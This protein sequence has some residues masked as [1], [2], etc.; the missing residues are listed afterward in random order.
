MRKKRQRVWVPWAFIALLCVLC[1]VLALLQNRWLQQLSDAENSRLHQDLQNHLERLRGEFDNE[2]NAA[3]SALSPRPAEVNDLGVEKAFAA[4]AVGWK[5]LH[6]RYFSRVALAVPR[7]GG[8]NL[9]EADRETGL[10]NSI[11]WPPEWAST[12]EQFQSRLHGPPFGPPRSI[13]ARLIDLPVFSAGGEHPSVAGWILLQLDTDYLRR[14]TIPQLL[15]KYLDEGRDL[16]L[17]VE[18]ASGRD[19]GSLI[20]QS[21]GQPDA[22]RAPDASVA[23]LGLRERPDWEP[24]REPMDRREIGRSRPRGPGPDRPGRW[25]LSVRYMPGSLEGVIKRARWENAGV[26]AGLLILILATGTALV[27]YSRNAQKLAQLQFNFVAGVSHELRTPVTIIRT[28]AHNLRSKIVSRPEQ[29]AKYSA[30]IQEESEKLSALVTQ[31]LMFASAGSGNLVRRR[32]DIAVN[33][34]IEQSINAS[35]AMHPP[36][37]VI[38]SWIEPGLPS[39]SV[40]PIA[41]QHA[42]NNLLTNAVKYGTGN[43]NWI[44]ISAVAAPQSDSSI[45][46]RVSDRGPGI[47]AD[48][49]KRIFEP[50]F[51]GDTP[52]RNQIHGTGLGL[53]LVRT[54]VE[55]HGGSVSVLSEPM[56]GAEFIVR[57]PIRSS[58]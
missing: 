46:I 6:V 30:L 57:L 54:I 17:Q 4:R 48:E 31:V 33:E 18:V 36:E 51:R 20:F 44:G 3:S 23:L 52:V 55:A 21:G 53:S 16:K 9:L 5:R 34:L 10:L 19:P 43:S 8:I 24:F 35:G 42:L 38:E 7:F 2:I 25:R 39:V 11:G 41:M 50:F 37:V 56:C 13:D 32:E 47:P 40:D 12:L 26:S 14:E 1:G 49:Q 58:I 22:G 45:E 15:A 28:A 29:V 27:R